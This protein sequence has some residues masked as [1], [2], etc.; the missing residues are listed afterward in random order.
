MRPQELY[1]QIERATT[2]ATNNDVVRWNAALKAVI[3]RHRPAQ[4]K[5]GYVTCWGCGSQWPCATVR[6][7]SKA[8]VIPVP[9]DEEIAA[10][11]PLGVS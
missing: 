6:D 10:E 5:H 11:R 2:F 1:A 4:D 8:L 9:T 7:I 3:K